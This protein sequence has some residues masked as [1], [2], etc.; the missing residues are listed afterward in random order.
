MEGDTK[1]D[2]HEMK[3][4][5][6]HEMMEELAVAQKEERENINR[7]LTKIRDHLKRLEA[8]GYELKK[9]A[10]SITVREEEKPKGCNIF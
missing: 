5:K 7:S 1:S 9:R 6:L 8:K 3:A 2:V 4:P 10:R